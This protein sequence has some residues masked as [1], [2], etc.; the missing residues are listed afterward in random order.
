MDIIRAC[1]H[2]LNSCE[3]N[4]S[5]K[6]NKMGYSREEYMNS[7]DLTWNVFVY[8]LFLAYK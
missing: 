4:M 8:D 7:K 1:H 3:T 5:P 2:M 6:G